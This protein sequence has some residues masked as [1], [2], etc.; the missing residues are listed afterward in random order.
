MHKLAGIERSTSGIG[1]S[2]TARLYWKAYYTQNGVTGMLGD[3]AFMN[4]AIAGDVSGSQLV[5]R[6]LLKSGEVADVRVS[7]SFYYICVLQ[8]GSESI[9]RVIAVQPTY[10]E[11]PDDV[12]KRRL[13][14]E[15]IDIAR[16]S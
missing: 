9:D 6:F 12:S 4:D 10:R 11:A 13:T 8:Q 1:V 14:K 2:T 15:W 16:T 5:H 7:H 3:N